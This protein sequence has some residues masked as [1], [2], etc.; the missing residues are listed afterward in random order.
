L[1]QKFKCVYLVAS[2]ILAATS[3]FLTYI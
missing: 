3:N 2:K 1:A